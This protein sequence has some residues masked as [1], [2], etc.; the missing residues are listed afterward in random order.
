MKNLTPFLH[1]EGGKFK[2]SLLEEVRFSRYREKS[3][4]RSNTVQLS[5]KLNFCVGWGATA[6]FSLQPFGHPTAGA[7]L[8]LWEKQVAFEE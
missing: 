4:Q 8:S 1:R 3:D 7:S 5:L 6:P 2:V